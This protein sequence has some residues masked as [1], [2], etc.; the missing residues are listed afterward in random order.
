MVFLR[1]CL[2]YVTMPNTHKT[3]PKES[4][5]WSGEIV[6]DLANSRKIWRKNILCE[7]NIK[8]TEIFWNLPL[9]SRESQHRISFI[10]WLNYF[11][12]TR[13]IGDSQKTAYYIKGGGCKQNALCGF[14]KVVYFAKV[15]KFHVLYSF[16]FFLYFITVSGN[17]RWI[18]MFQMMVYRMFCAG[19]LRIFI[20]GICY[21][22][23][24]MTHNP[25]FFSYVVLFIFHLQYWWWNC[26]KHEIWLQLLS[27][28][29]I[30]SVLEQGLL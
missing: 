29:K 19:F 6:R 4:Y 12:E 22:K 1:G 5:A 18:N 7:L 25:V 15:V 3:S 28:K 23:S 27:R 10:Y 26:I 13:Q 30:N 20:F 2:A 9:I 8:V 16:V 17:Y 21:Q 24:E 11:L 14:I